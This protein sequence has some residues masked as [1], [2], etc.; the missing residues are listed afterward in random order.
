[1]C[2]VELRFDSDV[3]SILAVA[4]DDSVALSLS[5][6]D[7]SPAAHISTVWAQCIG[8]PLQWAWLMTNQQGYTDAVRLEFNDPENPG[9][10]VVELVVAASSIN[11]YLAQGIEA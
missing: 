7:G 1:M 11:A 6:L 3:L 2:A 8:K 9:S 5:E 10:T 4:K